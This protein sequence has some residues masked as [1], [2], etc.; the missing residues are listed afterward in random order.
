MVTVKVV[1]CGYISKQAGD[2]DLDPSIHFS[3]ALTT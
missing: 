1:A 2:L 3:V